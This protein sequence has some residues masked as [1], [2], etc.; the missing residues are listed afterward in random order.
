MLADFGYSNDKSARA[1]IDKIN[2]EGGIAGRQVE[3][4][5]EDSQSDGTVGPRM[6]TR[7]LADHQVDFVIGSDFGVVITGSFPIVT[8][9]KVPHAATGDVN[10]N[11]YFDGGRYTYRFTPFVGQHP[12]L[13]RDYALEKFGKKWAVMY[14]DYVWGQSHRDYFRKYFVDERGAEMTDIPIPL[15]TQ[16]FTPL[17]AKVP[18]DVDAVYMVT[19]GLFTIGVLSQAYE[20]GI[21]VPKVGPADILVGIDTKQLGEAGEG[22]TTPA[23]IPR[24]LES[25]NTPY[26]KA[27][28]DAVGVD[29]EGFEV[30][31][32]KRV[33]ELAHNVS[34]W[35]IIHAIKQGIEE[36]GW[37]SKQDNAKW[38]T[39]L[40]GE[41][42]GRQFKE[43]PGFPQGN[44]F[45]RAE[46]HQVMLQSWVEQVING[47]IKVVQGPNPPEKGLFPPLVDLTKQQL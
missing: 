13:I 32:P 30:G 21:R 10:E 39:W 34:V 7:L 24:R 33:M 31:N 6:M 15:E 19:F 3:Y 35:E 38:I 16:D 11:E 14:L 46:D 40:E 8:Q 44:K 41:G 5:A 37:Q 47:E 43:G 1:A 29:P 12:L 4:I 22:V 25:Y 45:M 20:M 9:Y 26:V 17:L 23:F 27:W 42:K 36:T 2:A 18:K 28:R